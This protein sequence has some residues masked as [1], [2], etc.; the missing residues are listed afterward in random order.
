MISMGRFDGS[1][2]T[3]SRLLSNG[4]SVPNGGTEQQ[5]SAGVIQPASIAPVAIP[6]CHQQPAPAASSAL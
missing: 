1:G 5:M 2:G 3:A 4:L 6:R